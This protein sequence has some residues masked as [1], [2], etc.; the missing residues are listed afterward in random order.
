MKHYITLLF[1]IFFTYS[2]HI[3]EIQACVN[4][5]SK[6]Y[7]WYPKWEIITEFFLGNGTK[8]SRRACK[9]ACINW[10]KNVCNGVYRNK[11]RHGCFGFT[12]TRD[13]YF[14]VIQNEPWYGEL[15]FR[16]CKNVN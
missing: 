16:T 7:M 1:N 13:K 9:Q 6:T 10:R 2:F 4:T 14:S 3:S 8:M 15:F 5:F 12:E 11:K